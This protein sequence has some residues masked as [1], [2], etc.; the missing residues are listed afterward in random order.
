M[1]TNDWKKEGAGGWPGSGCPSVGVGV[2]NIQNTATPGAGCGSALLV[3]STLLSSY[4]FIDGYRANKAHTYADIRCVAHI[5]HDQPHIAVA[6]Y[7]YPRPKC[8]S[9]CWAPCIG[10]SPVLKQ[11]SNTVDPGTVARKRLHCRVPHK[12]NSFGFTS[13][14]IVPGLL[15]SVLL[16]KSRRVSRS[17]QC[18]SPRARPTVLVKP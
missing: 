7:N 14:S 6:V 17:V 16:A 3:Q 5:S 13:R 9:S 2:R 12:H 8:R 1:F 11:S 4:I 10:C 18:Y 15:C